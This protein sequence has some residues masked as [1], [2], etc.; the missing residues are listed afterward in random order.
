MRLVVKIGTSSLTH[1]DGGLDTSAISKLCAEVADA[2]ADGHQV[3]LVT[4]AAITAGLPYL[5]FAGGGRP[6]DT[7]TLQAAAAVGQ[8]RLLRAYDDGFA[9]HGLVAGQ[10][11]LSPH[12]FCDRRQYLHARDTLARL[13]QLGVV[14]VVN[15]NDAVADDEIRFGDND[16]IAALVAHAVGA[17][18]LVLLT[19]TAGLFTADPRA[20]EHASLVEEVSAAEHELAVAVGGAGTDRGSGGMASKLAAARMA[21]WTGTRAVIAAATRAGVLRGAIAGERVG[22]QFQARP[23]RLSARKLWIAF[24]MPSGGRIV[25]DD[26]ARGALLEGSSSL[27]L[28]G[29]VGVEGHF[30]ADEGVEIVDRTGAVLAKGVVRLDAPTLAVH[31]GRRAADVPIGPRP[32][33]V[34]RDD[35]VVLAS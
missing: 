30:G 14:P 26:G 19:D 4:S 13:V 5:G 3:V 10:V 18:L 17:D 9:V 2:R 25:V 20:D 16:R 12:D 32:E 24:A 27:L 8:S 33:V 23:Q 1:E 31:A 29:V 35:L 6:R 21:T 28:P 11:L 15:E 34:H 22:T 7:L